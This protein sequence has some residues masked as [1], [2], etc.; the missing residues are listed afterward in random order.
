M[1]PSAIAVRLM[2]AYFSE[3]LG[4][5]WIPALGLV[6]M[7]SVALYPCSLMAT[8]RARLTGRSDD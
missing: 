8:P 6:F 4:G 5:Y 2:G 1:P 7:A 3:L